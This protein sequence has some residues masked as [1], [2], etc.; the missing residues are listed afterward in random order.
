MSEADVEAI[1]AAISSGD[2]S[3]APVPARLVEHG[4]I[5]ENGLDLSIGRYLKTAATATLDVPTALAQLAEA[6]ALLQD[7]KERLAER[8]KAAGYA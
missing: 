5:K 1:V 4:E 3:D 2:D 7:A 8:L 6:E